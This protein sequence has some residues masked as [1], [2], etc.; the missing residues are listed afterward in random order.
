MTS[1]NIIKVLNEIIDN[2]TIDTPAYRFLNMYKILKA[3][4]DIVYRQAHHDA[5]PCQHAS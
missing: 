1:L 3:C 2:G 4:T 5:C